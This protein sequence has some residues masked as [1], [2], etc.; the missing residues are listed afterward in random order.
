[1]SLGR[2]WKGF[3]HTSFLAVLPHAVMPQALIHAEVIRAASEMWQSE[4]FVSELFGFFFF[5]YEMSWF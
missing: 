1:M 2:F 5:M 3:D 4:S